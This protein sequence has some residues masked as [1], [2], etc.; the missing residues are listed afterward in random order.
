MSYKYHMQ[1]SANSKNY[2]DIDFLPLKETN[3]VPEIC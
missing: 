1:G 2:F 3:L